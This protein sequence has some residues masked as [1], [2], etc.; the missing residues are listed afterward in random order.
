MIYTLIYHICINKYI[1]RYI[2]VFAPEFLL[3]IVIQK[4]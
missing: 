3:K 4:N 2:G 1:N